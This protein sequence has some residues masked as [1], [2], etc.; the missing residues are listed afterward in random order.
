M[1]ARYKNA[2][3]WVLMQRLAQQKGHLNRGKPKTNISISP[4]ID[5]LLN[6]QALPVLPNPPSPRSLAA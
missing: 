3:L 5:G 1:Q 2:I 4:V 6:N